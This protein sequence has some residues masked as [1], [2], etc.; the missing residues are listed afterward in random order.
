MAKNPPT[1][2]SRDQSISKE[3]VLSSPLSRG[4]A[5]EAGEEIPLCYSIKFPK[6]GRVK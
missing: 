5:F 3:L 4:L 1:T 2:Q 6:T